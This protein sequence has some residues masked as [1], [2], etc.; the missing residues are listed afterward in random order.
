MRKYTR[1]DIINIELKL[2]VQLDILL[3]EILHVLTE[4]LWKNKSM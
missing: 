4:N 1:R 2:L 3:E